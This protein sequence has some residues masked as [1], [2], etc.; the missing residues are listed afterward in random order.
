MDILPN[1]IDLIKRLKP[2][3]TMAEIGVWRG[4]FGSQILNETQV[5]KLYEID[6]WSGQTGVYDDTGKPKTQEEH[7]ADYRQTLHH[8]RGHIP[9][10]R[11]EIIRGRS[12]DVAASWKGPMLD[13]VYI[14]AGH[15]YEDVFSDL[16]AW[17]PRVKSTGV[18]MGH[19]YT[20]N[21]TSKRF[22]W[23]VKKA[24]ADFCEKFGWEITAVTSEDFASYELHHSNW[25]G[26]EL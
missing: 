8:L 25:R 2:R 18:L 5:L 24:V 22:G 7:D 21:D 3:S 17:A 6:P 23:G 15:T 13:A 16:T 10:K 11:V 20:D 12:I 4:Y 19:D 1:R 26:A 14:D 9:G